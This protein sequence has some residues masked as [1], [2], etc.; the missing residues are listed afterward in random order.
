MVYLIGA[1]AGDPGLLSVRGLNCLAEADVVMYDRLVHPSLLQHARADAERID[2][3]PAAPEP[4]DQEAICYLLAEKAR[5]G[6]T[7]ARLKWGDPYVFDSGGKE[8][9]FLHEQGVAFEVAP[10]I[11]AGVGAPCYA[12]IP[13]TYPGGGDTLTFV[14]GHESEGS[15]LP[16]VDWASL[17]RLDGTIVCYAGGRQ[18]PAILD[19]L[20]SHGC[21]ADESAALIYDGTF[22]SQETIEGTAG[23][24]RRTVEQRELTRPAIL[25]VG[26]V[27]ALR[28]HLRWFDNR[29]LSGKRIVVTRSRERASELVGALESLGAHVIEAPTVAVRPPE[30]HD[31][32][33]EACRSLHVFEAV[34]FTSATAAD[35]FLRRLLQGAG[36]LRDLKGVALCAIGPATAARLTR[37]GLKVD[38][39]PVDYRAEALLDALLARGEVR[40]RRFLV[41]RADLGRELLSDGLRR[42]GAEVVEVVAYQTILVDELRSP[43]GVDIYRMLLDG[44]IDLVTFTSA[45]AVR[46]FV[47]VLGADAA[48]DLLRGAATASIGPVTAEAAARLDIRPTIVPADFT[49]RGLVDAIVE[50]FSVRGSA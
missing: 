20:I 39:M 11:P 6:K 10:G 21:S 5:E 26:R 3:G 19:A 12:G 47:R 41:P 30:N 42:A 9:L 48:A 43:D 23:S 31:A 46:N 8:A 15:S 38:V 13:I 36:D 37:R 22:P 29:P 16:D 24:I 4:M 7:V 2:V 50:H 27:A 49:V 33:D 32:L 25:V 44:R 18:L 1:G 34:V 40:G 45:S 35:F 28:S 17:A 14:R